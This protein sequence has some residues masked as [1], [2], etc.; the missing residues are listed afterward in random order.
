MRWL[1]WGILTGL[2]L[3]CSGELGENLMKNPLALFKPSREDFKTD[4]GK[5]RQGRTCKFIH[6]LFMVDIIGK[7]VAVF[8][9]LYDFPSFH[10]TTLWRKK[11]NLQYFFGPKIWIWG[12]SWEIGTQNSKNAKVL[13]LSIY[14]TS[15]NYFLDALRLRFLI[16]FL[17]LHIWL[18]RLYSLL[19]S[20]YLI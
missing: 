7:K 18:G 6:T 1:L 10:D 11:N 15:I 16:F 12:K 17:V 14:F 13:V 20:L 9:A 3:S 4:A 5:Y 2:V 8:I 19:W